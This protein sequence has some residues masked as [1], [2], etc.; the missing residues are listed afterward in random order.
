MKVRAEVLISLPRLDSTIA[1]RTGARCGTTLQQSTCRTGIVTGQDGPQQ[2]AAAFAACAG[3][4]AAP[5]WS[6]VVIASSSAKNLATANL[7]LSLMMQG[8]FVENV[9]HFLLA[10]TKLL[11]VAVLA[12]P[13]D[14]LAEPPRLS[15]LSGLRGVDEDTFDV[16]EYVNE[17]GVELLIYV[18]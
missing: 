12:I 5:N 13:L 1:A 4:G 16:I 2:S 14:V 8:K 17:F 15:I 7:L 9:R 11:S 18:R 3:P 10:R 6:S